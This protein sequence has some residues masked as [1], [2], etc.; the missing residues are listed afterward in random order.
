[1][2]FNC[3]MPYSTQPN[4]REIWE[5]KENVYHAALNQNFRPQGTGREAGL[6]HWTSKTA[7]E[8]ICDTIGLDSQTIVVFKTQ[9]HVR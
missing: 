7:V 3:S 9:T 2:C 5:K 6:A 8:L 4:A 1:M